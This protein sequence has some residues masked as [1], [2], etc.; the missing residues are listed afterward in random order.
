MAINFWKLSFLVFLTMV[1]F[2]AN[3]LLTRLA[4][5]NSEIGPASFSFIRLVSG[6]IVL[7]IIVNFRSGRSFIFKSKPNLISIIGLSFYMVG[8][9]A[10]YFTLDAGIG[11]MVLFGGV[12]FV[13]FTSAI[14]L[15]EKIAFYN[16]AGMFLAMLGILI[17]FFPKDLIISEQVS[18]LLLMLLAAFGWG[19]YSLSGTQSKDPIAST[20]SNFCFTIP[21]VS[22]NLI[23]FPDTINVSYNGVFLAICSGAVMSALG[24][25]MWYAILPILKKTVASIVQLIVPVIT[26]IMGIIILDEKLTYLSFVSS[27]LIIGGISLGIFSDKL[28]RKKII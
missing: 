16:W 21:I 7:I 1:A 2:A 8:F 23:L 18:G 17:L 13:M 4:I 3:S 26:L 19:I 15:K 12:Q 27:I 14:L 24:Y 25:S 20:M 9:H 28:I 11:A 10:A 22:I 6:S 5:F